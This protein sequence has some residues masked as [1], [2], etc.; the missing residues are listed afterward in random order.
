V[1]QLMSDGSYRPVGLCLDRRIE[2]LGALIYVHVYRA[3]FGSN[4]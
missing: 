2:D 4:N 3:M 1:D